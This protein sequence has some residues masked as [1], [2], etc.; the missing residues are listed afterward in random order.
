VT[1]EQAIEILDRA[2]SLASLSRQ[3]H[4]AVLEA[5]K[6]LRETLTKRE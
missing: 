5:V 3:D 2:A 6:V 4:A 1:A